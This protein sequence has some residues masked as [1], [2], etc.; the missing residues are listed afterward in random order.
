MEKVMET[1]WK[2]GLYLYSVS[3]IHHTFGFVPCFSCGC[4]SAWPPMA[5]LARCS[6][7]TAYSAVLVD[8]SNFTVYWVVNIDNS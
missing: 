1:A 7:D 6:A 5:M 2:C 3:R 4:W 8:P